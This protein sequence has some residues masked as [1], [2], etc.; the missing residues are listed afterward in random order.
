[1]LTLELLGLDH[2]YRQVFDFGKFARVRR[3]YL[4]EIILPN[5]H[6]FEAEI[7]EAFYSNR[8]RCWNLAV[9]AG[10]WIRKHRGLRKDEVLYVVFHV[11]AC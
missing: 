4:K 11:E 10:G 3:R 7:A 8:S 5:P 9:R 1:M 6:S 2:L